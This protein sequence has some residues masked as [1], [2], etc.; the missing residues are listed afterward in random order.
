MLLKGK[1]RRTTVCI[2]LPDD[3]CGEHLMKINRVVRSNLRVRIADVVSVHHCHDAKYGRRVHILPVD[4]T[5]EGMTGN[6]FEFYLKPYFGQAYRPVRKGDLFLVRGGMRSVEFKVMEIDDS[7]AGEYCIVAPE[8]EIFCDGEPV[9]RED[10]ERLD[11]VSYDD[12]GGMRKQ[13][14]QIRE[15]VEL[16]LKIGRPHV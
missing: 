7:A 5:I 2:A 13:M 1:R 15:L 14:T 4:D 3:T 11:D 16:P 8:T 6:L 12:V 10:E 9:K